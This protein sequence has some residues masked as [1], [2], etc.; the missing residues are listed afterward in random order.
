[1]VNCGYEDCC[2]DF[3][4]PPHRREYYLIHY[5]VKGEGY[6]T[7]G[8]ERFD[9]SEGDIFIIRPGELVSYYSPDAMKTWSFCWVGFNG[10]AAEEYLSESGIGERHVLTL[11]SRVFTQTVRN[12][13]SYTSSGADLSPFRLT[14]CVLDV[15]GLIRTNCAEKRVKNRAS[16][17]VDKAI[18]YIEFNYMNGIKTRDVVEYLA[19]DRSYLYRLFMKYTRVSPEQY[20]IRYRIRK[21]AE[22]IRE[23]RFTVTEV[24]RYVGIDDVYHFSKQFKK[25]T[26]M[27]P[28]EYGNSVTSQQDV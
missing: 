16:V 6:F 13:L 19:I 4:C 14:G 26:G 9:L 25:V 10:S 2:K 7:V 24:S 5:I 3:K 23:K 18:Q 12:C 21:A 15:L 22:L 28:S 8:N 20:L 27:S 1:M 17:F 11:C